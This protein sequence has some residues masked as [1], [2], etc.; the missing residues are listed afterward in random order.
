ME[1]VKKHLDPNFDTGND[2]ILYSLIHD[3]P[4]TKTINN[5]QQTAK[6][7][8]SRAKITQNIDETLELK[9]SVKDE[10]DLAKISSIFDKIFD[11]YDLVVDDLFIISAY[12]NYAKAV[13]LDR[14]FVVFKLSKPKSL[15]NKQKE[16]PISFKDLVSGEYK[17]SYFF[18]HDTLNLQTLLTENY[19]EVIGLSDDEKFVLDRCRKYRNKIHFQGPS[20][21]TIEEEFLRGIAGLK[22]RILT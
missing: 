11:Q 6:K 1:E 5:L 8:F 7:L 22:N 17:D 10:K 21:Y 14:K 18:S 3:I 13:L 20:F 19:L 15:K 4:L 16:E 2:I 12:E 9:L